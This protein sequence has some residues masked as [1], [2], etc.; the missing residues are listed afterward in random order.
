MSDN[1]NNTNGL[2]AALAGLDMMDMD[3]IFEQE[4]Q[5]A[6]TKADG[7]SMFRDVPLTVTLEVASAEVTLGELSRASVGDV[8]PL[9]KAVGEPLDVK[10]NGVLFAKAEVV[11]VDGKYGL[12]FVNRKAV[13][14]HHE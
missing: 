3:D 7:L 12:K 4:G 8:L 6:A 2:D 10:V 5:A 13:A 11:M 9:E 1:L 14:E